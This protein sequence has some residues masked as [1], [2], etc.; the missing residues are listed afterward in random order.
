MVDFQVLESRIEEL[1]STCAQLADENHALRT[2][3]ANLMSERATLLE[4]N[5]LARSRIEAM[6]SRLKAMEESGS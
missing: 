4:K 1:V 5:A 3:Q 2:Q 6:I